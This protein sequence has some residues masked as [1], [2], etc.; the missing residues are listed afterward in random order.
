ME[1]GKRGIFC[2]KKPLTFQNPTPAVNPRK[3]LTTNLTTGLGNK[4][5]FLEF[6]SPVLGKG[7]KIVS[8]RTCITLLQI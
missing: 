8:Q 7:L 5:S 6:A 3:D 2:I 4:L 1:I